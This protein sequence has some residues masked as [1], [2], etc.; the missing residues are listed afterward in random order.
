MPLIF[1]EMLAMEKLG[2]FLGQAKRFIKVVVVTM[3]I[4]ALFMCLSV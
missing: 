2:D 1:Y 3:N 4:L